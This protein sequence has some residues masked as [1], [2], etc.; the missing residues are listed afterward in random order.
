MD[1]FEDTFD[2]DGVDDEVSDL[3]SFF[4]LFFPFSFLFFFFFL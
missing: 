4:G 2:V 3:T 1:L